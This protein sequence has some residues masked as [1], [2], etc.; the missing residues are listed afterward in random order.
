M[1]G[2]DEAEFFMVAEAVK[3]APKVTFG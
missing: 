2:F 1:L 3:E